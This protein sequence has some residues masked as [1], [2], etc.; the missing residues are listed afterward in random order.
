MDFDSTSI[1]NAHESILRRFKEHKA[2][3]LLGTQMIAKGLDFENVT[4][5]G[6][7]SADI[8]LTLPDFR[9]AE[10]IFQ[11]LTQVAG[12]AGRKIKQGEVVIQTHMENHYAIQYA[13]NHNFKG[14]YTQEIEYRREAGYPPF[15]R[16]IK[17]G[18][19]SDSTI[20]I[21]K[22]ARLIVHHLKKFSSTYYT[23]IGPA[24]APVA[25]LKN[26]YRWQVLLKV[27]IQKDKSIKMVR[28]HLK[29]V[30]EQPAF[31]KGINQ[32]VSIDVD[33]IDM[34]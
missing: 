9:S 15:T 6:V 7:I 32:K 18:I 2:D 17:I 13:K 28:T 34:M 10:R 24:P 16:L 21:N 20:E 33:P 3:I 14:F 11:L 22:I 1:K 12:R 30:L 25:R 27:D 5:V 8:G 29:S 31:G 23:V 26:K 19:T 4:L